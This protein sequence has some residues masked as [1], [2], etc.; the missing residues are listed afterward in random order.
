M[1]DEKERL[2]SEQRNRRLRRRMSASSVDD[3]RGVRDDSLKKEDAEYEQS[4]REALEAKAKASLHYRFDHAGAEVRAKSVME[5]KDIREITEARSLTNSPP[6]PSLLNAAHSPLHGFVRHSPQDQH[7][8]LHDPNGSK[9]VVGRAPSPIVFSASEAGS[10]PIASAAMP[11]QG[12][13]VLQMNHTAALAGI[14][15]NSTPL[16]VVINPGSPFGGLAS[17]AT[18]DQDLE[19][20]P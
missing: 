6:P 17:P 5:S 2:E 13:Q 7:K 16:D 14:L 10:N 8:Q 9:S 1:A 12:L 3:D 4:T 18:H 20:S 15:G 11:N 19:V